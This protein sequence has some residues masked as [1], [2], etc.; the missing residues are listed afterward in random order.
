MLKASLQCSL[1]GSYKG[2]YPRARKFC[3]LNGRYLNTE[4]NLKEEPNK[5]WRERKLIWTLWDSKYCSPKTHI[6]DTI[7]RTPLTKND[8]MS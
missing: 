6:V 5:S 1:I 4:K 8:T 7:L 2:F 3:R